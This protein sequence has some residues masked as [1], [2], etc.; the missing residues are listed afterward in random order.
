V[1]AAPAVAGV[2]RAV[3]LAVLV[4]QVVTTALVVAEVVPL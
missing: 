1:A 4:V 3:V 2:L